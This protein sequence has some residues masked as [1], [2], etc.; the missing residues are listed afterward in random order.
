MV[1]SIEISVDK[2]NL[3]ILHDKKIQV[4]PERNIWTHN[5]SDI[6]LRGGIFMKM[7][8]NLHIIIPSQTVRKQLILTLY[9]NI[10]EITL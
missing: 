6:F 1:G 5:Y 9:Q 8:I 10:I 4:E 7:Y 2:E 3:R